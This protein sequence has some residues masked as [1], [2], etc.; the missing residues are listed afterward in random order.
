MHQRHN[1][2]IGAVMK[3]IGIRYR[4]PLGMLKILLQKFKKETDL[5]ILKYMASRITKCTIVMDS[6][7]YAF[8]DEKLHI[9]KFV[10]KVEPS[11]PVLKDPIHIYGYCSYCWAIKYSNKHVW[12]VVSDARKEKSY[13]GGESI[14]KFP[15]LSHRSKWRENMRN[16]ENNYLPNHWALLSVAFF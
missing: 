14:S 1:S 6:R 13:H 8:G 2:S 3:V 16:E 5:W 7:Y 10:V 9:T 12:P 4:Y 11:L 15:L